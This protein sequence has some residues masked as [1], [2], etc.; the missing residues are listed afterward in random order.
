MVA[1][2]PAGLPQFVQESGYSESL[3]DNTIESQVDSGQPKSRPRFTASWRPIQATIWLTAAEKAVFETFYKHTLNSG[4][5]DFFWVNPIDQSVARF[6]FRR[7]PPRYG[8]FGS[9]NVAAAINLWQLGIYPAFR[10]D[11][12]AITFDST[13]ATFDQAISY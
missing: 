8:V 2:W 11:S 1:T 10:F 9:V 3:G 6:R 12:T 5:E 13:T 7:P 4:T